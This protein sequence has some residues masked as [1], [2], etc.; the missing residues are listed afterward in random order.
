[1]KSRRS[2]CLL[3]L[4]TL[5]LY[6]LVAAQPNFMAR[7]NQPGQRPAAQIISADLSVQSLPL[8]QSAPVGF[9]K[10]AAFNAGGDSPDSV[11]IG[12]LNG[13]GNLDLVVANGASNLLTVFLGNGDGTFQPPASYNSGGGNPASVAIADLNGDGYPDLI[14]ANLCESADNCFDFVGPGGVSVL[15]GKR[16]GTFQPAVSYSSGAF[17]AQSVAVADVNHDG[18]LDVV[19][20]NGCQTSEENVCEGDGAVGVLMGNGDGTLQPPVVYDSGGIDADSVAV[21]DVNRDGKPDLI[22]LNLCPS[23]DCSDDTTG[24]VGVLLGNGNGT[25]Q[26]AVPYSTGAVYALSA[27]VADLNGDGNLDIV[28]AH[29]Y[30]CIN[31]G[32]NDGGVSVL[33]GN[34]DG[35]FQPAVIYDSGGQQATAIAVADVNGD[36]KP[37]LIA[38]N[39]SENKKHPGGV[40]GV[41]AGN[42]DGTFQTP[43][44]FNSGGTHADSVAIGDLN[45][46]GKADVVVL[47]AVSNKKSGFSGGTIGLLLNNFLATTSLFAD[48]SLNPSLVGQSVTFTSTVTSNPPIPDGEVITFFAGKTNLGSIPVTNGTASVTTTF[49]KARA[50]I[51][52]VSYAGDFWHKPSSGKFKQVV[53]RGSAVPNSPTN[54]PRILPEQGASGTTESKPQ[55]SSTQYFCRTSTTLSTSGS[56]SLMTL[57]VSFTS[58]S[59]QGPQCNGQ[60]NY[61]CNGQVVFYDDHKQ[62][63]AVN[64]NA[65]CTASMDTT[66]LSAGTH[67]IS[68][69]FYPEKPWDRSSSKITQVVQ[70]WP[71][72]ATL[73]SSPNPS[74][75]KQEVTF[76]ANISSVQVGPPPTGQVKFLNGTKSLGMTVVDADGNASITTKRLAVGADSITAEYLG[77]DNNLTS[78]AV[79]QQVVNR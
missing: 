41:L 33:L 34:G 20:S 8:K 29:S 19:A 15:L 4:F 49:S 9:A 64:L 45:R 26:A 40:I 71:T 35:T 3:S 73:I 18:K 59:Y 12:D 37:D 28:V 43:V 61:G 11:A 25:F 47:D 72:A 78:S 57:D 27:G 67:H 13:D 52:N 58:V 74:A 2:V 6:L 51:I 5:A 76:S 23:A 63:G 14:V 1:M 21:A 65:V 66:S 69:I 32:A 36:G 55:P 22:V 10:I 31:C 24:I 50:Y 62:I 70:K 38:A 16:D 44:S 7:A 77:D 39:L 79:V 17:N 56:P 60:Q 54:S 42:G 68:A 48:T 53:V 30:K 75:Y 46:D